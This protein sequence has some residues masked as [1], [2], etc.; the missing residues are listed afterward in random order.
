MANESRLYAKFTLDYADSHKIAPLS[1]QAFRAHVRMILWSRRMLSDGKIPGAMAKV[2]CTPR[3]LRELTGNDAESP[4]LTKVGDDYFLHDF[5]EHQSSRAEV[6]AMTERNRSN[7]RRGGLA[8]AKQVASESVSETAS[9]TYPETQTE[10]ETSTSKEVER[11]T[12]NLDAL[13]ATAWSDW[14][15]KT[16]RI[17]ARKKFTIAAKK[18]GPYELAGFVSAFG[19]AYAATTEKQFVPGL[20]TWLNRERW[21]DE[22]PTA[23]DVKPQKLS[24]A[25]QNALNFQNRLNQQGQVFEIESR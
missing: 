5:T 17:D 12:V 14:P 22:M 11:P 19:H 8:K 3:V 16:D 1:D 25:E 9:E 20:G 18:I 15:K 7:G 6:E 24:A 4:S 21:T 10:T 23:V 13:F 2:F